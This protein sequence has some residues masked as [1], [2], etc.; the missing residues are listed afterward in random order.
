MI[1]IRQRLCN[2]IELL[3]MYKPG[4]SVRISELFYILL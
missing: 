3:T 4:N 1:Q 2:E